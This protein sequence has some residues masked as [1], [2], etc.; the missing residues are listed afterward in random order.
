VIVWWA[1]QNNCSELEEVCSTDTAKQWTAPVS[2][3]T[4]RARLGAEE[5]EDGY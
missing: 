1:F 2:L 5:D 4:L 3:V